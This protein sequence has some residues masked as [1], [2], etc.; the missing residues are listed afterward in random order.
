MVKTISFM[1]AFVLDAPFYFSLIIL[2]LSNFH[3]Y[4]MHR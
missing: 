1:L 4:L 2:Q 3:K